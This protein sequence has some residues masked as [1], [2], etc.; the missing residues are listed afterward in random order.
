[1]EENALP[2]IAK[3]H[4]AV[5]RIQGQSDGGDLETAKTKELGKFIFTNLEEIPIMNSNT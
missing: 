2:I 5:L 3:G 1:M 4:L